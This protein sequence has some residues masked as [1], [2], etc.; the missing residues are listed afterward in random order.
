[1]NPQPDPFGGLPQTSCPE[2]VFI[3]DAEGGYWQN[4]LFIERRKARGSP[5]PA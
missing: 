3:R 5:N 1:V 4:V 2:A